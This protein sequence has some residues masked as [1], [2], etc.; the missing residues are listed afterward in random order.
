MVPKR[1]CEIVSSGGLCWYATSKLLKENNQL[2]S[3][4]PMIFNNGTIQNHVGNFF[5]NAGSKVTQLEH[6]VHLV[7]GRIGDFFFLIKFIITSCYGPLLKIYCPTAFLGVLVVEDPALSL[8]WFGLFLWPCFYPWHRNVHM[9]WVRSGK[10]KRGTILQ[11]L[12][13]L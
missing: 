5:Q 2:R 12:F 10:K 8:L 3:Q 13:M 6:L 9:P 11:S 1:E 4:R 7:Q